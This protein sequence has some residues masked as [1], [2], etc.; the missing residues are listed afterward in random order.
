M[1][2]NFDGIFKAKQEKYAHRYDSQKIG[3]MSINREAVHGSAPSAPP[4]KAA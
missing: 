1:G 2:L 4:N 3:K